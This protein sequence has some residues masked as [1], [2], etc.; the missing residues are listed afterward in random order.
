MLK[1]GH[2]VTFEQVRSQI[3]KDGDKLIPVFR[4]A[5]EQRDHG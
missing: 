3:G 5:D 4:S 2:D 1:F